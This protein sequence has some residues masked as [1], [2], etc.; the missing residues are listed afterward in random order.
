MPSSSGLVKSF[1]PFNNEGVDSRGLSGPPL[2]CAPPTPVAT[3]CRL[4]QARSME[5]QETIVLFK[6]FI[7]DFKGHCPVCL[8]IHDSESALDHGLLGC[9]KTKGLCTKCLSRS[10]SSQLEYGVCLIASITTEMLYRY[11]TCRFC[12]LKHNGVLHPTPTLKGAKSCSSGLMDVLLPLLMLIYQDLEVKKKMEGEFSL[13]PG[14]GLV[15]YH[16]WLRDSVGKSQVT[17]GMKVA[18]WWSRL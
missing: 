16:L 15:E 10:C 9:S 5:S 2:I 6:K 1:K 12:G 18:L 13:R 14:L 8:F 3:P 17:N 7:G 4:V 11:N